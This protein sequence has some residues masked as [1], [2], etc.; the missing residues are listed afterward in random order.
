MNESYSKELSLLESFITIL[1]NDNTD[2]GKDVREITYYVSDRIFR[3]FNGG[4]NF[5]QINIEVNN[6]GANIG[7][8]SAE[9]TAYF[10]VYNSYG[11]NYP[12][13]TIDR[14]CTRII[15]LL[16]KNYNLINE[17]INKS[18]KCR[19][20]NHL[21]TQRDDRIEIQVYGKV[22]IF[23]LICDDENNN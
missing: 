14:I 15:F 23:N 7:I 10:R 9:Y 16:N 13:D 22:V 3:E 8:P 4:D 2:T 6:D 12:Q 5:P 17:T 19:F 1:S 18:I 20:I 11:N 21:A